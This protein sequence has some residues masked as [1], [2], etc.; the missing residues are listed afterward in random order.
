MCSSVVVQRKTLLLDSSLFLQQCAVCF[1]CLTLMVSEIGGKQSYSCYFVFFCFQHLFK[2]PVA[3]LSR[4]VLVLSRRFFKSK[5][6]NHKVVLT[7]PSLEE[8]MIYFQGG[9]DIHMMVHLSIK[10]QALS[11][12]RWDLPVEVY[13]L[14]IF[15]CLFIKISIS[16]YLLHF[17]YIHCLYISNWWQSERERGRELERE[18]ENEYKL[19]KK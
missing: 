14:K 12:S 18:N 19:G 8:F 7:Q 3:C 2:T 13:E 6:C 9:S 17:D 16:K 15:K 1:A 10:V 4:F 11:F 5:G